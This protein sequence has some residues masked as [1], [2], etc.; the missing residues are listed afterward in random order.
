MAVVAVSLLRETAF[1]TIPKSS[2]MNVERDPSVPALRPLTAEEETFAEAL[3]PLH[4]EI[5]E[6]AA[7]RLTSAGLGFALDDHDPVRL[8]A[9]L[10]PLRQLFHDTREQVAVIPVPS[11]LQAARDRY[12]EL[13]SL[14]EQSATEMLAVTRD[15]DEGHLVDA[16]HKSLRAAEELEKVGDSLW[17]AEHKPN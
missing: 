16:Q 8:G 17:P 5:V 4:Q 7:G 14:Y 1:G 9:Q 11:S 12:V 13:L 3:W 6:P 2:S 15:G 10:A